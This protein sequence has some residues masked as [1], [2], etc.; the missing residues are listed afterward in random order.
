MP[1]A[2]RT[3]RSMRA[4]WR[5]RSEYLREPPDRP[6]GT[7]ACFD[8]VV[9][10]DPCVQQCRQRASSQACP[11]RALAATPMAESN[12]SAAS[13]AS[14]MLRGSSGAPCTRRKAS[15]PMPLLRT[16][17]RDYLGFNLCAGQSF[18]PIFS[19]LV[20]GGDRREPVIFTSVVEDR[21]HSH[22]SRRSASEN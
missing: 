8:C 21:Q 1:R 17:Q 4:S 2:S 5:T 16:D 6:P 9:G 18:G 11:G 14:S 15:P 7:R 22:P 3:M 10:P 19:L 12:T 13:Y 20:E